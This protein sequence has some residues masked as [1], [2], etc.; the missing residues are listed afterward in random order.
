[1]PDDKGNFTKEEPKKLVARK[2]A[3]SFF[4]RYFATIEST[5]KAGIGFV[6]HQTFANLGVEEALME[7]CKSK[8]QANMA[9]AV[10]GYMASEGNAMR[11]F[12]HWAEYNWPSFKPMSDKKAST[13]FASLDESV[14]KR[15]FKLWL[16]KNPIDETICYLV[17]SHSTPDPLFDDPPEKGKEIVPNMRVVC[18][19]SRQSSL[20]VCYDINWGPLSRE[21]PPT[22]PLAKSA[23]NFPGEV[24]Y[25]AHGGLDM[26][27]LTRKL[28][29][30]KHRYLVSCGSA[31]KLALAA[32]DKVRGS[33]V[34]SRFMVGEGKY[35]TKVP[36]TFPGVTTQARIS[37]DVNKAERQKIMLAS[38]AM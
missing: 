2:A 25:V 26:S 12:Q 8:R 37:F 21:W 13:F 10:A 16:A 38:S 28:H 27:D 23:K 18:Y 19:Y 5:T 35:S 1:M 32:I 7:A 36:F 6:T 20:P 9:M 14:Q 4:N 29:Q 31:D 24:T 34:S 33:I 22:V 15:F 17:P 11:R 3:K 30:S